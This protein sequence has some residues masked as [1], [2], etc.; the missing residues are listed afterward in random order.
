[1]AWDQIESHNSLACIYKSIIL[2]VQSSAAAQV[3][4]LSKELSQLAIDLLPAEAAEKWVAGKRGAAAEEETVPLRQRLA[5]SWQGKVL[6]AK[7]CSD[8]PYAALRTC[9]TTHCRH[10][11]M[12]YN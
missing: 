9:Q 7:L 11:M 5:D 1:M 12:G 2:L 3:A 4:A 10:D 8:M 6:S